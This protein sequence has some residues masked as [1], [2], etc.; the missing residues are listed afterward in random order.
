MP[1]TECTKGG[2]CCHD[3]AATCG[4]KA[5]CQKTCPAMKDKPQG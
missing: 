3:G 2:E 5:D 1:K 4:D